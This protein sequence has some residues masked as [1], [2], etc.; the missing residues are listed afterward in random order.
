M[1]CPPPNKQVQLSSTFICAPW[2]V[3]P[4]PPTH[5]KKHSKIIFKEHTTHSVIQWDDTGTNMD[6]QNTTEGQDN[7]FYVCG[8][9]TLRR[10]PKIHN[11]EG[12]CLPEI[13]LRR[14]YIYPRA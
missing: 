12:M 9:M 4:F 14:V 6:L 2:H 8:Q 10:K 1:A 11:G 5:K 13:V 7:N 3:P